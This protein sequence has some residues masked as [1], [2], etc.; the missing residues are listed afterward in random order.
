[1]QH[2]IKFAVVLVTA[3]MFS[4]CLAAAYG[5]AHQDALADFLDAPT[6]KAVGDYLRRT[7]ISRTV[8]LTIVLLI[9]SGAVIA[10]DR[11]VDAVLSARE[12]HGRTSP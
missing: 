10:I 7:E 2:V 1:M 5:A 11:V 9:W 3:V 4:V 12:E 6:V 8:G